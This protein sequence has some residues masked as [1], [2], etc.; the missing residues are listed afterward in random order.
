MKEVL[1]DTDIVKALEVCGKDFECH[2]CPYVD[3]CCERLDGSAGL[4]IQALDLIH[5]LQADNQ[6]QYEDYCLIEVENLNL[7]QENENLRI[8]NDDLRERNEKLYELGL[9]ENTAR[10]EDMKKIEWLTEENREIFPKI[11]DFIEVRQKRMVEPYKDALTYI[12]RELKLE[13]GG[14]DEAN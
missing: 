8:D 7:R 6:K 5:R 11:Y 10:F 2:N 1:K 4:L 13:F 9:N 12:L 14:G 3:E